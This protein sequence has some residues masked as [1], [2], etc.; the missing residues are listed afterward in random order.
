MSHSPT[1][2]GA[3]SVTARLSVMMFLQFFVWG[4]WYV[5]MGTYLGAN[6]QLKGALAWAYSLVPIA[7]IISPFFLG[8]VADRFFAT[9]RILGVLHVLGGIV[10]LGVPTIVGN[11]PNL[12]LA[13]VGLHALCYVPTLGLTNSLAFHNVTDG[14]RQFP[15]I[16]VFGTIGWIVA[17]LVVSSVLKA[18]REVIQFWVTGGSAILLGLYSFTLPHTPPPARGQRAEVK[19]IL[20]LDSL[21]L[22]KQRSFAVFVISSFLI[23][24]PLAAY[25]QLAARFVEQVGFTNTASTMSLGQMSEIL[26]MLVMPFFFRRLGVKWM[27]LVGMIAWVARYGLF[28]VAWPDKLQA[29]VIAGIVLHGICYDFFFVTGQIYVDKK[30]PATI[31]SQAQGF[32]VLVT[33]GLGM[34]IGAQAMGAIEVAQTGA[35]GDIAWRNLWIIPCAAAG[36]IAVLFFLL[37]REDR[38]VTDTGQVEDIRGPVEP[39][40]ADG[41]PG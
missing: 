18:D 10:M 30:A 29:L 3:S 23:C 40:L 1:N 35:A 37:F 2:S 6:D 24:I 11:N 15:L 16:R 19:D 27:L 33:Q 20:G 21:A 39:V 38:K 22:M 28:A 12:F 7:A 14:E 36:V 41:L 34:F 9:E 8:I 17:N 13:V 5:S 31:R 26:F 25:Y 4:S 32:L